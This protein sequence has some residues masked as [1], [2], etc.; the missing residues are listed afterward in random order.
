MQQCSLMSSSRAVRKPQRPMNKNKEK[1]NKQQQKKENPTVSTSLPFSFY[2]NQPQMG[3]GH[4]GIVIQLLYVG[5]NITV[6]A[7]K[8]NKTV[9]EKPDIC[10][11]ILSPGCGSR[12]GH[13]LSVLPY[14]LQRSPGSCSAV[15]RDI[16]RGRQNAVWR[17]PVMLLLLQQRLVRRDAG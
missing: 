14:T 9:L 3:I 10:L 15:H 7:G 13:R 2:R 11:C 1:K 4:T 17:L 6:T 12:C 8:V 16:H 5:R